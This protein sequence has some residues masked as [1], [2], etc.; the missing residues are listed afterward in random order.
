MSDSLVW[1][2]GRLGSAGQ[3]IGALPSWYP[4]DIRPLTCWLRVPRQMS[5]R[6][7]WKLHDLLRP[8]LIGQRIWQECII[9][10][11]LTLK[12]H[13][14]KKKEFSFFLLHSNDNNNYY[15]HLQLK[16]PEYISGRVGI[17]CSSAEL[18]FSIS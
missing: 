16:F 1:M 2:A 7:K 18:L 13:W 4:Q 3:L 14:L 10:K 9:C 6:A 17:R 12:S 5:Q 11:W 15:R 8:N